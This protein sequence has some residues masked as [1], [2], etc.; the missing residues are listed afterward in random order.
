MVLDEEQRMLKNSVKSFL[1]KNA[2]VEAMR[3]LRNEKDDIG[4]SETLW[5]QLVELGVTSTALPEE[6][7]GLGFGYLGLGAV[8]EEMG[9]T[10]TASPLFSSLVLCAS[11][12]EVGGNQQQ[13][14]EL[15]QQI[16]SGKLKLALAIDEEHHLRPERTSTRLE[17]H[18]RSLKLNGSK[19]FVQDGH[20]ADQLLVVARRSG[21]SGDSD[22]VT[23]LLIAA[24]APGVIIK[25]THMMDGRNAATVKF[26]DV[27]LTGSQIIGSINKEGMPV[28]QQV[29]DRGA[30]CMAAEMLGGIQETFERTIAYLKEREQFGVKIASFQ[31]LQHRAAD[32]Y[33][34]IEACKSA[35]YDALSAIDKGHKNLSAKASLAKTLANECYRHVTNEAVQMHGGMGVTD[36]LDI[37]LFLKRARVCAQIMGDSRYHKN[38]YA[39]LKGY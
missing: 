20:S 23:L 32:L 1:Q 38:R 37:G 22:G 2:P 35:V 31:A 15:L 29:L 9:R 24:D 28:L 27:S 3:K 16:A 13:K 6:F 33:C 34:E 8:F 30:I 12:I 10:L 7:G 21:Q 39:C 26:E 14:T 11:A 18:S 36:E 19:T 17:K 5:Q 4:Y 25:R